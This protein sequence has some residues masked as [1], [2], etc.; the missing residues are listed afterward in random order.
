[1]EEEKKD[2]EKSCGCEKRRGCCGCKCAIAF[3]LFLLGGVIGYLI[4]ES[5]GHKR[6]G[7]MPMHMGM[8]MPTPPPSK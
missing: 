3:I 6:C 8:G 5:G 7:M 2:G 4:G 1:M